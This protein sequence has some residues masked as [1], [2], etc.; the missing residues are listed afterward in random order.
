MSQYLCIKISNNDE[1]L[2]AHL[3]LLP[4]DSF[5]E[6]E[7][8]SLDAYILTEE[9]TEFVKNEVLDICSVFNATVTVDELEDKN[10]N[11][12]WESNF[13][14]VEVGDFVRIRADFHE[15]KPGFKYDLLIHPKMAFGTGHHQTTY[16]MMKAMESIDFTNKEVFDFGCGTGVL[17]LLA[18][19]LG[20]QSIEAVDIEEPSYENTIE[21]ARINDCDNIQTYLGG[22]DAVPQKEYDII[23]A[24]INR[25]VLLAH[26]AELY[27]LAKRPGILLLSGIL[28][29]DFDAINDAFTGIGFGLHKKYGK[30]GWLC[31][32]FVK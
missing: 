9:Y 14:P 1:A 6:Q 27:A 2:L 11:E 30:E 21:N 28:D 16:T 3:S 4:F 8:G 12:E 24:N 18:S 5:Q 31:L 19:K 10:W 20:A 13:Q 32:E 7:D 22:I 15:I 25:N 23:L 26:V 17:S 29:Q